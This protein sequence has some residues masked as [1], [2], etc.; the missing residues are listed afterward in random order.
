MG[1]AVNLNSTIS[2]CLARNNGDN[3]IRTG[4]ASVVRGCAARDNG[5]D[6]I[7][8][9]GSVVDC[10]ASDNSGNGIAAGTGSV[11]S[12]CSAEGNGVGIKG[13]SRTTVIDCH[14]AGSGTLGIELGDRSSVRGTDVI[15]TNVVNDIDGILMGSD[16]LVIGNH[17]R[18]HVNG[19][20]IIVSGDQNR[21][22]ANS[23]VNA[24]IGIEIQGSNNL[25]IRNSTAETDNA[26]IFIP[27]NPNTIGPTVDSLSIGASGNPHA[28]YEH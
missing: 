21:V 17:V 16:S 3:G 11:V 28:N 19:S 10:S 8:A 7:H 12:R 18:G 14:V 22:E 6:G 25:V 27:L 1:I 23:V 9:E 20:G 4:A 26:S 5:G 15:N 2:D 13:F 24:D